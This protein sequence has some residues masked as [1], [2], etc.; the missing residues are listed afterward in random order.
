MSVPA[1][2][3]AAA[4][5]TGTSYAL[6]TSESTIAVLTPT[7]VADVMEVTTRCLPSGIVVRFAM[8]QDDW[9]AGR[10]ADYQAAAAS[11]VQAIMDT[12]KVLGGTPG[13]TLDANDLQQDVVNFT[14]AYT[15]PGSQYGPA[16]TQVEIPSSQL[17]PAPGTDFMPSIVPIMDAIG[18][19]YQQLVAAAG[20]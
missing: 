5:G 4:L 15:P 8:T 13:Q 18:T 2:E 10:A 7:L 6:I 14:V 19:A 16:T 1:P 12:G 9:D 11:R 3:P 20:G 17:V